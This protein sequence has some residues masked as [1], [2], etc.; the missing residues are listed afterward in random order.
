MAGDNVL[1]EAKI[2]HRYSSLIRKGT[3]ERFILLRKGAPLLV[4]DLH[5]PN[6][7]ALEVL[8]RPT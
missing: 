3:E 7:L 4:D 2:L 1:V 8:Y 5:D 6:D